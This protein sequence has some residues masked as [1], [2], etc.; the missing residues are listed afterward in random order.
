MLQR[1]NNLKLQ[2]IVDGRKRVSSGFYKPR[3]IKRTKLRI[4]HLVRDSSFVVPGEGFS[5]G[6][7]DND[8]ELCFF[9]LWV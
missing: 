7:N 4:K 2:G 3:R 9:K 1:W 6:E 5:F 8:I